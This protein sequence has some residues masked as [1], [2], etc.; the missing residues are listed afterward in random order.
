VANYDTVKAGIAGL[1]NALGYYESSKIVD[2]KNSPASEYGNCYI[3]KCLSGE[4]QNNTIIDRFEDEQEWL[5]QVA[6]DRSEHNDIIK[7]DEAQRAKDA[8]IK[9]IDKPS[10]W[11]SFVKILK[12]HSWSV[13][14]FSNYFVVNI[15]LDVRDEYVHG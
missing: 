4:N 1:L 12:Y 8:I 13:E 3:L 14:E 6:F 11:T 15:K 10:N 7:Y 9:A 2:F 5:I